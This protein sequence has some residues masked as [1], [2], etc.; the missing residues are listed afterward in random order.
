VPTALE[1]S[2][3][4]PG[5]EAP[6]Y[7]QSPAIAGLDWVACSGDVWVTECPRTHFKAQV[8]GALVPRI[9]VRALSF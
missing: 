4:V 6:G 2:V 7:W 3:P 1:I 5:A 9:E 8:P